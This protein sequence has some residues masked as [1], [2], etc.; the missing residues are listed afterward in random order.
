MILSSGP[1]SGIEAYIARLQVSKGKSEKK[2]RQKEKHHQ[3][4]E[5]NLHEERHEQKRRRRDDAALEQGA[6]AVPRNAPREGGV[7][8]GLN[9]NNATPQRRSTGQAPKDLAKRQKHTHI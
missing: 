5:K 4:K 9:S 2:A 1:V 8:P 7:P 6:E 3:K